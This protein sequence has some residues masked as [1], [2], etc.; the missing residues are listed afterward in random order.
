MYPP[1]KKTV[2]YGRFFP[3]CG[4]FSD[5]KDI[6][7]K[8]H[9]KIM[10]FLHFQLYKHHNLFQIHISMNKDDV[11]M[12]KLSFMLSRSKKNMIE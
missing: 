9:Q 1:L 3:F 2:L 11:L 8:F 5:K 6:T 10:F 7:C 12:T 4:K